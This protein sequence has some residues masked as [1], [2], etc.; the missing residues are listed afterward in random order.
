MDLNQL[1]NDGVVICGD[2]NNPI[3]RTTL[4]IGVP[5]SGTTM[6]ATALYHLGIFMGDGVR[7]DVFEDTRLAAALEKQKEKLSDVIDD[8]NHRFDVWG[9]KRPL[10]WNLLEKNIDKFRNPRFV[11]MFRDPL[12]V[13]K[14][15]NVSMD[16]PVRDQLLKATDRLRSL[17]DFSLRIDAPVMLVS[18]EKAIGMPENF[19]KYLAKFSGAKAT[20]KE[21][22][23]TLSKIRNGPESYL[24]SSQTKFPRNHF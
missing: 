15:N 7:K 2:D 24:K 21:I 13:A 3:K 1:E 19:V 23:S 22:E 4:I 12:A 17:V 18:Y 11:V 14:R 5:R 6:P 10:A 20:Q 16:F 8:Y 9:F